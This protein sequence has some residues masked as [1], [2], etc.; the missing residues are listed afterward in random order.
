MLRHLL[1][2]LLL[3][4]PAAAAAFSPVGVWYGEGEPG[5]PN[6]M[7]L[8]RLSPDGGFTAQ[9]RFCRNRQSFDQ[10][11][12]GTWS[13]KDGLEELLTRTVNG[14]PSQDDNSYRLL[15]YDGRKQVYRYLRTGFVF[16]SVRVD[17]KFPMPQCGLMS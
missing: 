7:W 3:A 16:T 2:Y 1:L 8:V 10:F 13:F 17:G 9:F 12:T 6:T 15:S 5:D 14:R 4:G 11:E